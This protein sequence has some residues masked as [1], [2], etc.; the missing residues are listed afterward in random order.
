VRIGS[1]GPSGGGDRL[2]RTPATVAAGASGT[3]TA[4]A[5]LIL[6]NYTV[7]LGRRADLTAQVGTTISV[8]L[9][10]GQQAAGRVEVM[11]SGGVFEEQAASQYVGLAPVNSRDH[12]PAVHL[13]LRAGDTAQV[14]IIATAGAGAMQGEGGLQGVEYDA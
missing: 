3:V 4:G 7:P 13:Q 2:D 14:H 10:A 11:P 8:A 9:A 6:A 12:T 1:A 5:T